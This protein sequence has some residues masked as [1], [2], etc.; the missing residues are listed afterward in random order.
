MGRFGTLADQLETTRYNLIQ[1]IN[2]TRNDDK[3]A[4]YARELTVATIGGFPMQNLGEGQIELIHDGSYPVIS[5]ITATGST[6]QNSR[7]LSDELL[8]IGQTTGTTG[9]IS[10]DLRRYN[11]LGSMLKLRVISKDTSGNLS[12]SEPRFYSLV[13]GDRPY[14]E[15]INPLE[16]KPV[17]RR[18]TL[19]I[20]TVDTQGAITSI[21]LVDPGYGYAYDFEEGAD[22]NLTMRL[23]SAVGYGAKI[24]VPID[25]NGTIITD[26]SGN[27]VDG[28]Y[29]LVGGSGYALSD[30][31]VAP[32]P[33]IYE[34]GSPS[35][36]ACSFE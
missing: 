2:R 31:I 25:E 5:T 27:L 29:S 20:S 9:T 8:S 16:E 34:A 18:A 28:N 12:Y 30:L 11:N 32:A 35:L 17:A 1:A 33:Y 10:L 21:E 36:P 22:N 6:A 7:L 23:L 15:L 14:V 4:I 24:R 26:D 19:R 13:D 3:H